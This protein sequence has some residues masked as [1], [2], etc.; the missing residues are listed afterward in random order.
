MQKKTSSAIRKR[1]LAILNS[2][3]AY[4]GIT[5]KSIHNLERICN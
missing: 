4:T 2:A 5:Q 1:G 3:A